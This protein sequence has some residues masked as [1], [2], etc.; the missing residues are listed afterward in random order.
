MTAIA[1]APNCR[2][3]VANALEASI[4]MEGRGGMAR[5]CSPGAK[6][7]EWSSVR[8]IIG[9]F[10]S[11]LIAS[12]AVPRDVGAD[13]LDGS[14]CSAIGAKCTPARKC[15]A[16]STRRPSLKRFALR[17]IT[18]HLQPADRSGGEEPFEVRAGRSI[19]PFDFDHLPWA[20]VPRDQEVDLTTV[21]VSDVVQ[22]DVLSGDVLGA[23]QLFQQGAGHEI[24]RRTPG[25]PR[26]IALS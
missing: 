15:F 19:L 7:W 18:D 16:G 4:V 2:V 3:S 6:V 11:T 20:S 10:R 13:R 5:R 23:M 25:S 8:Q 21:L 22:A 24:S 14:E 17:Q 12:C 26:T 1:S 9:V